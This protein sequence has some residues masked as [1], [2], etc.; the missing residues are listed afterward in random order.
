MAIAMID[1]G[2]GH[3]SSSPSPWSTTAMT[4]IDLGKDRGS[5]WR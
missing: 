4:V 5:S 1:Q 3:E 2:D